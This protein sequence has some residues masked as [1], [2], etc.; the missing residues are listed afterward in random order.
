MTPPPVTLYYIRH[1]ETEWSRSGQHTGRT[2]IA[3]TAHGEDE[4]R[5]LEPALR[6]LHFDHVLTSPAQRAKRTCVLAGLGANAQVEPDLAEWDYGAY[7]GRTSADI[8]L[9]N[10]EWGVYE[11]GGPG[12]ETP[13]QMTDRV[14][15]LIAR[16]LS[17]GGAIA[18]FSHGHFG[19]CLAARWI[20]CPVLQGQHFLLGTATLS[21]LGFNPRHPETRVIAHWNTRPQGS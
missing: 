17:L 21:V 1:G 12:G 11:H 14:D 15:R 4:A 13:D 18:L 3:L 2:D 5:A 6:A 19:S 8:S 10:P 9:E 7:E 20:G 16:L